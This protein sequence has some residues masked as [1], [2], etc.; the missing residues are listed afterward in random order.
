M[1]REG[2]RFGKMDA[3][4]PPDAKRRPAA[5]LLALLALAAVVLGLWAIQ[6][7][8]PPAPTT[9]R[10]LLPTYSGPESPG[11]IVRLP[12][13]DI[14]MINRGIGD[15]VRQGMTFDVYDKQA[16]LPAAQPAGNRQGPKARLELIRIG[17]GFSE[18]RVIQRAAGMPLVQGDLVVEAP[19]P[20][21]RPAQS[22]HS[23]QV[24][25]VP[26]TNPAPAGT[27]PGRS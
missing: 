2:S 14:A 24:P 26:S 13:R 20:Q 8:R 1:A 3:M 21:S 19:G 6:L 11:S 27:N 22:A 25:P 10:P 9:V 17:P 4:A 16:G 18:C 7:D 12:G 5:T 15:Q 23:G